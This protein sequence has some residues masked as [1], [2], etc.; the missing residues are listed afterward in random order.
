MSRF[1]LKI[2]EFLNVKSDVVKGLFCLNQRARIGSYV[3]RL[4]FFELVRSHSYH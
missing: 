4:V 3:P 2:Y 1:V